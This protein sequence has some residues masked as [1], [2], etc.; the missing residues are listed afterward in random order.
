MRISSAFP[1]KY[2]KAADLNDKKPIVTISHVEMEDVGQGENKEMKP[3][4]YFEGKEKG[5]VLNKTNSDVLATMYGDDTDEW[6]GEKVQLYEATVDFQGKRTAA[7]RMKIPTKAD[8]K[9]EKAPAAAT[10]DDEVPF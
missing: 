9:P 3:V 7:I 5:I 6:K 10:A 1:S 2:L 4:I 8:L